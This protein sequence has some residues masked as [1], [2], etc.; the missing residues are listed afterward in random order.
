MFACIHICI[1][2]VCH[3]CTGCLWRAEE[4]VR[5][6]VLKLQGLPC[7][8]WKVNP[9]PL[10]EQQ[11][12][13]SAEASL[14]PQY[15][16]F[17]NIVFRITKDFFETLASPSALSPSCGEMKQSQAPLVPHV[18]THPIFHLLRSQGTYQPCALATSQ[19]VET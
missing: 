12:L 11:M 15:L 4:G 13:F 1:P 9:D 7:G 19:G 14:W 3:V 16:D 18:R 10:G 2:R 8:C 6:P 17:K 5:S